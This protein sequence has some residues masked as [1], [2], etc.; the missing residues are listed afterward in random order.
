[1]DGAKASHLYPAVGTSTTSR[2]VGGRG[3]RDAAFG[4]I[5]GETAAGAALGGISKYLNQ[6]FED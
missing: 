1:M 3:G 4:A 5:Q 2:R 6:N